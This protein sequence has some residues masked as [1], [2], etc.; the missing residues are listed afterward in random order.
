MDEVDS[1]L[2]PL[3]C[4]RRLPHRRS[5]QGK[6]GTCRTTQLHSQRHSCLSALHLTEHRSRKSVLG[7]LADPRTSSFVA[8]L[9]PRLNSLDLHGWSDSGIFFV[10]IGV[11]VARLMCEWV[12]GCVECQGSLRHRASC[13]GGYSYRSLSYRRA[14]F[15]SVCFLRNFAP[16][17]PARQVVKVSPLRYCGL[18]TASF[19]PQ[20]YY[21]FTEHQGQVCAPRSPAFRT[22]KAVITL[23]S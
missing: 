8:G 15:T 21:R 22:C 12:N 13:L 11:A 20:S 4:K 10:P 17:L 3:R 9:K 14:S 5:Q 7:T 2:H 6:Q 19:T 18:W 1:Q 16:V 23:A